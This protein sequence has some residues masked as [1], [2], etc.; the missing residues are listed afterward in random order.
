L[1]YAELRD[2]MISVIKSKQAKLEGDIYKDLLQRGE[3]CQ[4]IF[5]YENIVLVYDNAIFIVQTDI[6]SITF[7]D[8][9]PSDI[10]DEINVLECI[11]FRVLIEHY[12]HAKQKEKEELTALQLLRDEK[13]EKELYLRLKQKYETQV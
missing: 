10:V 8:G 13:K 3:K 11:F 4:A 12:L 7:C 2:E 1:S 5:L 9:K 6:E